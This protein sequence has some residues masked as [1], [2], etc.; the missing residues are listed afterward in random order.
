MTP[1]RKTKAAK[2]AALTLGP[3]LFN[4][5]PEVWRDFYFR[6]A[7]EAPIDTVVI[8]EV[9]CSKRE[10]FFA[11]QISR[12]VDR[13]AACGK[14]V[15]FAT[16]ALP[17]NRREMKAIEELTADKTLMVEANDVSALSLL[18][19]R[20]HDVGP[21]VNVYNEGTIAWLAERG[22]RRVT[23]PIEL[24]AGQIAAIAKRKPSVDLEIFAFGRAPLALS[25]RCYAARAKGLR[26]DNCQFVCSGIVD[27]MDLATQDG[28]PFLAVN[29]TTT[30][31]STWI[32][33]AGHLAELRRIGVRRFRL[34]PQGIDMV[35]VARVFRDLLDGGD[36]A[37]AQ[38]QLAKLAPQAVFSDGFYRGTVGAAEIAA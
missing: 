30:F 31:S 29:G 17:T 7:D 37:K 20:P 38:R 24:S 13:L 6:I 19:G 3:V 11:P 9:V 26:K 2:T 14:E 1:R 18:G 32:D 23:L 35:S 22:A 16:L 15:V 4:W 33:L 27:G 36:A 21:H 25:A 8:G 10:P 34:S 12:V 28:K 5:A